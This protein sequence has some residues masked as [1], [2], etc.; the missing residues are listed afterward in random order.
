MKVLPEDSLDNETAVQRFKLEA[1]AVAGLVHPNIVHVRDGV[2]NAWCLARPAG[3][4]S[5]SAAARAACCAPR[6]LAGRMPGA[7]TSAPA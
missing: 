7:S 2:D 1:K 3:P 5:R 6:S 4:C